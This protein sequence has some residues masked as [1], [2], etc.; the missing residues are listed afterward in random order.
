[1][2]AFILS[3][4]LLAGLVTIAAAKPIQYDLPEETSAL[5]PGSG[6]DIA[7]ANCAA[8]HSADYI[9]TQPRNLPDPDAFWTAEV[10]KMRRVYGAP[11]EEAD[12]K[13]IVNYLVTAYGRQQ[14]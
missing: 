3:A 10:T 7:Q 12:V 8:C 9:S 6:Q 14:P 13:A 1:M 4:I 2:R 5:A 11:I